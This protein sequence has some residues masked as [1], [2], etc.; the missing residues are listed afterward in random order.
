MNDKVESK[1]SKGGLAR[2][3]ALTKEQRS[4]IAKRAALSRWGGEKIPSP[5]YIGTLKILDREIPCAVIEID[6]VIRRVIVQREVVGL[7]TGNKK[8]GLDRYL[9]AKNLQPFVPLKFKDKSLDEAAILLDIGGRK[10]QCYEAEDIVDIISMYLDARKQERISGVKILLPNQEHLAEQAEII[11]KSLAKVGIA[12]LIDEATGYQY[13][14]EK[15]A[16]QGYLEK[17]IRKEIAA[18]VQMFPN[19]FFEQVHKL[20]KWEYSGPGKSPSVV[21]KYINDLVYSRLGPRV[22]DELRRA[23]PKNEK[24]K[25][26]S[27]HHQWLTEDVGHP[28]LA[29][30]LYSLITLMRGFDNWDDFYKFA[31][32]LYPKYDEFQ[33]DLFLAS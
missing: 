7:L 8:G 28:M 4:D 11:I 20:H 10:A 18:W 21:G 13:V 33:K 3:E 30:H 15:D 29:Q 2:K 27:K 6:N 16:L 19:E 22:L 25:R 32:R 14:R 12:G 31:N 17:V 1:Q 23:N 5:S 24:G 9:A 26:K